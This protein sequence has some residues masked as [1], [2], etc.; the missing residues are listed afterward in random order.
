MSS[1]NDRVAGVPVKIPENNGDKVAKG[2]K[3]DY[4][5]NY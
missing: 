3:N 4:S 1:A 2:R 5:T